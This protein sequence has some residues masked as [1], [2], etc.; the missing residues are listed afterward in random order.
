MFKI[1]WILKLPKVVSEGRQLIKDANVRLAT[2]LK[3]LVL[4]VLV[5][6][7]ALQVLVQRTVVYPGFESL[8]VQKAQEDVQ[9]CIDAIGRELYHVGLLAT[10]WATWDDTY[11]FIEDGNEAFKT[12]NM[13]E[14]T[15]KSNRIDLIFF[16]NN[17]R[18]L[19]L[20]RVPDTHIEQQLFG[21]DGSCSSFQGFL[22]TQIWSSDELDGVVDTAAGIVLIS[23]RPILTSQGEGPCRGRL[24]MGRFLDEAMLEL[25]RE[26]TKVHFDAVEIGRAHV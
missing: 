7:T 5:L 8:E 24:V 4:G 9:R 12:S 6:C 2:L 23:S 14:E 22:E 17:K 19:V 11:A 15:F 1:S 13:A 16:L 25:L 10:D 3:S 20:S 18:Q 21:E 26:Q